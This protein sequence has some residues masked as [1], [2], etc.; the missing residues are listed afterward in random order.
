MRRALLVSSVV[1]LIACGAAAAS[2]PVAFVDVNVVPMDAEG[3]LEHQ[4]VV[5][6]GDRIAQIGR[7][8]DVAVP[9]G[10]MR[11]DGRGKFLMPGLADMH[12]HIRT[13]N[14]LILYVANGV[15]TV[16]NLNGS[17]V[18]L[19]WRAKT[20]TGALLGPTIYTCGPKFDRAR[21]AEESVREVDAQHA[22]GYDAIKIYAGVSKAEYPALLA[23]ARQRGMFVVGHVPR[24]VGFE[25]TLAAG[26][27]L[28]HAEEYVYT[29]FNDTLDIDKLQFDESRI[30]EA[31]A[32]T[33]R[34][35]I[36]FTPTLV[37]YDQIVQQA[38]DLTAFLQRPEMRFIGPGV[39]ERISPA[40]NIYKR[41]FTAAQVPRLKQNLAFQKKLV[42]ALH[43][44]GVPMLAGTDAMG[45]GTVGGFSLLEEL[46]NFVECGF[47]PYEAL[48][49]ATTDSAGFF[50]ATSEFGAVR[51]GLRADLILL[52]GNPLADIANVS[53]RAGVM[54]R[55]RWL[56]ESEL[57][58]ALAALPSEYQKEDRFVR[59]ALREDPA[60]AMKYLDEN[61]TGG[62]SSY[63]LNEIAL[64]DGVPAI[65]AIVRKTRAVQPSATIA[66][67]RTINTL[68]YQLLR[69]GRTADAIAV[70]I[71]NT[72]L[73]PDSANTYDSLA[74]GYAGSGDV[75][76]AVEFYRKALAVNPTYPNGAA[77]AEFIAKHPEM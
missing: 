54:V 74:E 35:G 17:P 49:A 72:E 62:L 66:A 16:F 37:T 46:E 77:A 43:Q 7:I 41:G 40:N 59:K 4:T 58:T 73:Y 45:I 71:F 68:G 13:R 5:I 52:T 9:A 3:I 50:Y 14:E 19:L 63:V 38:D 18:D 75:K 24:E 55:G 8:E 26:Q 56:T 39:R 67:E 53:R 2:K 70:F 42:R 27:A 69:T 31:V 11:I 34:S 48:R 25:G 1:F 36:W 64:E 51:R 33:R 10:S 57:Q 6:R 23:R 29:F 22:A 65:E 12:V 21:T 30:P 76:R 60:A 61:D 32:I 20:A 28:E 47:T 15:T 44:A